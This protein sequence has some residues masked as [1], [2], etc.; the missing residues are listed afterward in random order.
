MWLAAGQARILFYIVMINIHELSNAAMLSS[1][2]TSA[3]ETGTNNPYEYFHG[4]GIDLQD[5]SIRFLRKPNSNGS[6]VTGVFNICGIYF[7]AGARNFS[8]LLADVIRKYRE[9]QAYHH[10]CQKR[11][12]ERYCR[13]W[14]KR[15]PDATDI[16]HYILQ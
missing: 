11:K 3:Y 1:H 15:H 12:R 16:P 5:F 6:T 7:T 14:I 10:D 2:G 13:N 8:D 9:K 4:L